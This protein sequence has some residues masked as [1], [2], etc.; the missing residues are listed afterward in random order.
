MTGLSNSPRLA[1]GALVGI[2]PNNP[3][4]S[5][6]IFQYN[7]AQMSRTLTER[8]GAHQGGSGN[9]QYTIAG[10]PHEKITLQI[11]I[12]ATDQLERGDTVA[13]S[14]GIY[15]QLAALEII[16][17]PPSAD[18]ILNTAMA[19]A[20]S[21]V[22]VPNDPPMTLFIWGVKRVLPVKLASYSVTET[23]HDPQLNP[24]Q[25]QVDI[26][27]EVLTY[28]D[29]GMTHPGYYVSLAHQVVKETMATIGTISKAGGY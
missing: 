14:M 27:L 22:I 9:E 7:P 21:I 23:M 29:F 25:A 1:K 10:A 26:S 11:E 19:L 3:L 13:A 5:V 28:S 4:A 8:T 20:G 24:I 6:V 16:M 17:Y 18:V 2:D 12:D 15:P